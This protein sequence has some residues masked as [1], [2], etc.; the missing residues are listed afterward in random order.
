MYGRT[1]T[2][3]NHGNVGQIC[4]RSGQVQ[5]LIVLTVLTSMATGLMNRWQDVHSAFVFKEMYY[6]LAAG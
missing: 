2:Q 5:G 6:Q 1:L 3:R 4:L